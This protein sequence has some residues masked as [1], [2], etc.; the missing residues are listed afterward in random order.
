MNSADAAGTATERF[1]PG[2]GR[3]RPPLG[4]RSPVSGGFFPP[5]GLRGRTTAYTVG[6]RGRWREGVVLGILLGFGWAC[7][8]EL[9]HEVSC[10][11]RRVDAVAGE[12]C[13]PRADRSQWICSGAED[14]R[15]VSCDPQTCLCVPMCGDGLRQS[16]EA[17]DPG[18]TP[19]VDCAELPPPAPNTPFVSGERARCNPQTC[20]WDDSQCHFCGN[21]IVDP[22]EPNEPGDVTAPGENRRYELCDGTAWRDLDDVVEFCRSQCGSDYNDPC[23]VTCLPNCKWYGW[24]ASNESSCCVPDGFACPTDGSARCCGTPSGPAE[25][26]ICRGLEE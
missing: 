20:T 3:L 23:P 8:L 12:T 18:L 16:H 1:N 5:A 21:G 9:D 10:G 13:D 17:C 26:C 19:D 14:D 6:V 4:E 24:S 11:D 2:T 22:P 7:V 15:A 25:G